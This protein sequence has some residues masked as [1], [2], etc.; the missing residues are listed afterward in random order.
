MVE[1]ILAPF[2]FEQRNAVSEAVAAAHRHSGW[3]DV[4]RSKKKWKIDW[5]DFEPMIVEAKIARDIVPGNFARRSAVEA[6]GG[7]SQRKIGE[8]W[9]FTILLRRLRC[10]SAKLRIWGAGVRIPSDAPECAAGAGAGG[11]WRG[12]WRST[13]RATPRS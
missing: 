1:Q 9:S 10:L 5:S 13:A 11:S 3:L 2:R 6:A 7:K 4:V 8:G 12:P